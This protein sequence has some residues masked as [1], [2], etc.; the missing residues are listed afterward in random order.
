MRHSHKLQALVY[1]IIPPWRKVPESDA[2]SEAFSVPSDV[3]LIR[4]LLP[5]SIPGF[6]LYVCCCFCLF[7]CLF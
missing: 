1:D 6:S 2:R 5:V 7:V 3:T 4:P